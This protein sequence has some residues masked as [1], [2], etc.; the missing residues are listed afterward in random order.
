MSIVV[1][2]AKEEVSALHSGRKDEKKKDLRDSETKSRS[3]KGVNSVCAWVI[4]LRGGDDGGI[5]W[6]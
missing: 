3:G 5:M 4:F 1:L 6:M 2:I